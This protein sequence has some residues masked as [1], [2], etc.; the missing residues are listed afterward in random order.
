MDL[1]VFIIHEKRILFYEDRGFPHMG[2]ALFVVHYVLPVDVA[3]QCHHTHP[4]LFLFYKKKWSQVRQWK[5]A[6]LY[7]S[8]KLAR[9]DARD[10]N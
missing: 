7:S 1:E 5:H 8:V 3:A 10:L 2:R 9:P 6:I 4:R